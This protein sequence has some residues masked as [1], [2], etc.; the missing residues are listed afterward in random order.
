MPF[1]PTPVPTP[2]STE[3]TAVHILSYALALLAQKGWTQGTGAR[4]A[5]GVTLH[6][7]SPEATTFCSI[8]ALDRA[9]FDLRAPMEANAKAESILESCIPGKF[10]ITTWNDIRGRTKTQVLAKFQEALQKAKR[11]QEPSQ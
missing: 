8:G 9:R 6:C 10:R 11:G 2:T 4:N 7:I 5:K 1:D 3:P